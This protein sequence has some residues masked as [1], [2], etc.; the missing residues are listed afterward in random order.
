MPIHRRRN[1]ALPE[2]WMFRVLKGWGEA[3]LPE[4]W[5][6]KDQQHNSQEGQSRVDPSTVLTTRGQASVTCVGE[7]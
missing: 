4:G 1:K 2:G 7:C 5:M 3:I 6:P